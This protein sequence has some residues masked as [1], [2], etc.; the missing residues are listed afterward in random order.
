VDIVAIGELGRAVFHF[1]DNRPGTLGFA[2]EKGIREPLR[3]R[4]SGV[5]CG[6]RK[7]AAPA[8]H[9]RDRRGSGTYDI[10]CYY[11]PSGP[12]LVYAFR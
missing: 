10:D 12:V 3:N 1:E 7:A 8:Y 6:Y 9:S 5:N 2:G 4:Q 11:R